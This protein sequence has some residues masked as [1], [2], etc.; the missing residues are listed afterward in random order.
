MISYDGIIDVALI[1]MPFASFRQ[2][3]FA[4]GLLKS[5]IKDKFKVKVFDFNVYFAEKIGADLYDRIATWHIVDLLGDR[6]F[7]Q[8]LYGDQIPP[9]EE[10]VD[11]VLNGNL[12][13]HEAPYDKKLVDYAFYNELLEVEKMTDQFLEECSLVITKANPKI[14]AFTSMFHQQTSSLALAKRLKKVLPHVLVAFGGANCKGPMGME[15]MTHHTFIDCVCLGEGDSSFKKLVCACT[16]DQA[17]DVLSNIPGMIFRK[18]LRSDDVNPFALCSKTLEMDLNL[19]PTPDYDDFAQLYAERKFMHKE[20]PRVFF[21]M[22]RGCY[23]GQKKRCIFCGQS[24]ETLIFRKKNHERIVTELRKIVNEYPA[25][26]LSASDESVDE[27]ALEA[28]IEALSTLQRKPEIVYLQVRP[29][30]NVKML[31]KLA[32]CGLKRLEV[33]IESLS[34]KVLSIIGKG[35]N[36]L[37]NITF[38][39]NCREAGIEPIWNFLWGF[40]KEPESSY[41]NMA[42]LI[43]LLTHLHPPN[44]AGPFRL[45]RFSP[46]FENP[47]EHGIREIKPYPSYRFVYPFNEEVV[48]NFASFFTFKFQSPQNVK[49]YTRQLQENIFFWKEIYPKSALYYSQDLVIDKRSGIDEWHI[50]LDPLTMAV[51]KASSKPVTMQEIP[52]RLKE[53]EIVKSEEEIRQ[54]IGYLIKYGILL[55]EK[56]MYLSLVTEERGDAMTCDD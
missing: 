30:I 47:Y 51:C 36:G 26:A 32:V 34:S 42:N 7:A 5:S 55:K 9:F 16:D 12:K 49:D 20:K 2:P 4:L 31:K 6:L 35:V 18:D 38:L 11:K 40:P 22:S 19:V 45:D 27:G 54:S 39:K 46:C 14:V 52:Q 24:S 15:L 29:D 33:G 25:F 41:K 56:E 21:E 17:I 28:L 43:P 10:Y 8:T 23:W 44:Y 53:M 3:S 13:E 37:Q 1:N 50:R 48:D